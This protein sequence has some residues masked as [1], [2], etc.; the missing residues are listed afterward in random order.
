MSNVKFPI[1]GISADS[2]TSVRQNL[3]TGA[4]TMTPIYTPPMAKK[5]E[6]ASR[7]INGEIP[8]MVTEIVLN[9]RYKFTIDGHEMTVQI[10]DGNSS[11]IHIAMSEGGPKGN[12]AFRDIPSSRLIGVPLGSLFKEYLPSMLAEIVVILS[13]EEG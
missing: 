12:T 2:L 13:L 5:W 3:L 8:L 9:R 1:S 10:T 7:I 6:D 4:Y 11:N